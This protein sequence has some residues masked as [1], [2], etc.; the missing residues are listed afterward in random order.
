MTLAL[1]DLDNTLLAGDSDH[2][3]SQFLIDEGLV[4]A[5]TVREAADR[6]Y[7]DY[8]AGQLDIQQYLA[9]ALAFLADKDPDQLARLHRR[10]M[11]HKIEPILLEPAQHLL[12]EHRRAGHTLMIITATNAFVTRPIADRLGVEH[13]IASDAEQLDGRYTGRPA[14]TP[15]Y[16]E[17]KV[18]R[19]R[20]WLAGHHETLDDAWFYSDSHNDLPLLSLVDHPVAVD[21]DDTLRAHAEHHGW[22]IISLRE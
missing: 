10:F 6:F 17:G 5:D 7:A 9:F 19:L 2:A 13:L 18:Q 15:S 20:D 12:D 11:D 4:D 3:W 8:Q 1:F 14:G 22:P 21:P 16:R